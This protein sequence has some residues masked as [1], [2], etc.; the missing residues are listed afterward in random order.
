MGIP[1]RSAVRAALT[2]LRLAGG[3]ERGTPWS[4]A[5]STAAATI[6]ITG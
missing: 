1:C 2:E 3:L 5:D 6:I 4:T